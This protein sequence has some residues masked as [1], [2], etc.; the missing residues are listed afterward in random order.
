MQ[1]SLITPGLIDRLKGVAMFKAPVYKVIAEDVSATN[2]A[3]IIVV[4]VSA[5]VGLISGGI[6]GI[7]I[8]LL[9]GLL[10]W[11]FSSWLTAFIAKKFFNGN[12]N[13]GEMLRVF[14]HSYIFQIVGI[15]PI[16]GPLVGAVLQAIG[17]FFGVREAAE[18]D[19]TKAIIIVVIAAIAA[20]LIGV[21]LAAV[22]VAL[23]MGAGAI[24]GK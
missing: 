15:I 14:G 10:G 17:N 12:T 2:M 19:N 7:V 8:Q 20:M 3:A 22:G 23:G 5:I 11:A 9:G 16:V 21:V 24:A 4:V 6:T 1:N 13:T 18:V